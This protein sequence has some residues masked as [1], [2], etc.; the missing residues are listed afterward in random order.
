[1][2]RIVFRKDFAMGG[3]TDKYTDTFKHRVVKAVLNDHMGYGE[4]E[5]KFKVERELVYNWVYNERQRERERQRKANKD[6]DELFGDND[7]GEVEPEVQEGQNGSESI[8][9]SMLHIIPAGEIVDYLAR[10]AT[11]L[12]RLADLWEK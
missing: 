3:L 6:L 11:A 7:V 8:T 4:I 9:S 5:R 10:I 2:K 12:E 1:M